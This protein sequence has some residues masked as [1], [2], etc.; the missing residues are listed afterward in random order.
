MIIYSF[1]PFLILFFFTIVFL[2]DV[3]VS[4]WVTAFVLFTISI[5]IGFRDI[6]I[7]TD[8]EN[9]IN[10]FNEIPS[11]IDERFFFSNGSPLFQLLFYFSH[12]L[13]FTA[14]SALFICTMTLNSILLYVSIRVKNIGPFFILIF[15][16]S[17]SY[18]LISLN[19]LRQGL[20]IVSFLL[21]VLMNTRRTNT[22]SYIWMIV[23]ILFHPS[24][25][26]AIIIYFIAY[27]LTISISKAIF[28]ILLSLTIS[29]FHIDVASYALSVVKLINIMPNIVYRIEFYLTEY[30]VRGS[31]V[32]VGYFV[33]CVIGFTS[34]FF[35]KRLNNFTSCYLSNEKLVNTSIALTFINITL[36]PIWAPYA[37]I[38]RLSFYFYPFEML[39]F[40]ILVFSFVKDKGLRFFIFIITTLLLY[41]KSIIAGITFGF[42]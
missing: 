34:L 21:F 4:Q 36:Y 35:K 27:R 29:I 6:G 8:T 10:F 9:Y 38:S 37:A 41:L 3:K 13:G 16:T 31:V 15:L 39:L 11:N 32:G 42:L 17:F 19:I 24:S 33:T 12:T 22:S 40:C 5:L 30:D 23:S 14:S 28:I 18:V 1:I 25:I 2:C 26:I 20:A 7:G